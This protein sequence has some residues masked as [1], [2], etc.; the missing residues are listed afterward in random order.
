MSFIS[1]WRCAR[2]AA[3]ARCPLRS[4][5]P[6][7]IFGELELKRLVFT[8]LIEEIVGVIQTVCAAAAHVLRCL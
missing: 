8:G 3:C 6:Q 7:D 5:P 4:R 2:A 1:C